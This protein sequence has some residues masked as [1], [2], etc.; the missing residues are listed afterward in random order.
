[1]LYDVGKEVRRI[2]IN[3]TG[4]DYYLG[5][6]SSQIWTFYQLYPGIKSQTLMIALRLNRKR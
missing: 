6:Y 2:R 1:M 3:I 4:F 5:V